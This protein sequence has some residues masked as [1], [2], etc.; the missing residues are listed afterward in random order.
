MATDPVCGMT[1]SPDSRFHL[2]HAGHTYLFCSEHC[3]AKFQAAPSDYANADPMTA[4]ATPTPTSSGLIYTCPM[5]PE[6]RQPSPGNCPKC[7]MTLEV[8]TP[9]SN[10]A[11]EYTCPMHPEVVRNEPGNCPICGMALEPRNAPMEDE[12]RTCRHDAPLLGEYGPGLAGFPDGNG[13][14]SYSPSN[15][16]LRFD[17]CFAM[18]GIRAGNTGRAVGRLADIPARLGI[19]G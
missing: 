11:V 12:Y 13:C 1:V 14:R 10:A 17:A 5:H 9:P 7:G 16:R 19:R 6:I 8:L 15:T 4:A 2:A 18:A 3:L